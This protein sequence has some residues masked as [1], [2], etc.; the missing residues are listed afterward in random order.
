MKVLRFESKPLQ[1]T[2]QPRVHAVNG[3]SPN[4]KTRAIRGIS[5]FRVSM[6]ETLCNGA[7]DPRRDPETNG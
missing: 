1:Y 6:K 5:L 3:L 2:E 7:D 4:V